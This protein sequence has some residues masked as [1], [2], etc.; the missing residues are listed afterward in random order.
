[1]R[2]QGPDVCEAK[3]LAV[4]LCPHDSVPSTPPPF[5]SLCAANSSSVLPVRTLRVVPTPLRKSFQR[6]VTLGTFPSQHLQLNTRLCVSAAIESLTWCCHWPTFSEC[7]LQKTAG[8]LHTT[9]RNAPR[10]VSPWRGTTTAARGPGA[11]LSTATT[12]PAYK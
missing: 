3:G 4:V 10:E 2:C 7:V 9:E 1:M 11:S 8:S 12:S 5:L 6:R